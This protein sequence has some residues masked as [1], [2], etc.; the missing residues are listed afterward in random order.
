MEDPVK[1]DEYFAY[2]GCTIGSLPSSQVA[3][4]VIPEKF[5]PKAKGLID[6]LETIE[7]KYHVSLT[8]D[9]KYVE[10]ITFTKIIDKKES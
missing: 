3:K 2:F 7:T 6:V 4:F 5:I 1:Y 10:A 9:A 8:T